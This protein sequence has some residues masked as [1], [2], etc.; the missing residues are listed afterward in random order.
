MMNADRGRR[1]PELTG[2]D[3]MPMALDTTSWGA[4]R[5]DK[6]HSAGE[7]DEILL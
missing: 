7:R 2:E 4:G 1:I 6:E 3:R 5:V